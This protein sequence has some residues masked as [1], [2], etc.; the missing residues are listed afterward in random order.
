VERPPERLSTPAGA[1]WFWLWDGYFLAVYLIALVTTVDT[2]EFAAARRA[3]AAGALTALVLWYAAYG[4]RV[5]IGAPRA[6]RP[7]H[8][9]VAGVLVLLGMELAL[10]PKNSLVLF[11]VYPMILMAIPLRAA[12]PGIV[13]ACLLPVA[14]LAAE[15][16]LDAHFVRNQLV[17]P[18]IGMAVA[19][20]MGTF[21]TRALSESD[22]RAALIERLEASRA[23]VAR[24]SR[25]AGVAA[26]RARLAREIHDTLA[27]GFTSIVTLVQAA[28]SMLSTSDTTQ[29]KARRHLA[30]AV[31]TARE[32]LDEART[33]VA[34]L[35]PSALHGGSL[36]DAVRRQT[37]RLAEET[38]IAAGYHTIGAAAALPTAVEVVL[39]RAAQEALSNVRRHSRATTVTVTL[40]FGPT[41]VTL[42]VA[43]DGTGA[44]TTDGAGF[45]LR[46][47]RERAEQ[48]SGRLVVHAVPGK[49]T[50]L[51]LEVPW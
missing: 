5:I 13:V 4:R 31:R 15:G 27:Q 23:E 7:A 22:E 51:E 29:R 8:W 11:A 38:G 24:L 10:L 18:V 46:G 36:E 34:A 26:E 21:I 25:E 45:G 40:R 37:E 35:T 3:G 32:N 9:F 1:R 41:A 39:L 2:A 12:L 19:A 42:T 33:M 6:G 16:L 20:V 49:G 14:V 43:D 48:V 50:R 30:L 47:I 44:A 17:V 28:E